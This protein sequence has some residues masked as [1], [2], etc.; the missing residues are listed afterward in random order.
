MAHSQ[1]EGTETFK[2]FMYIFMMCEMEN[3]TFG[4]K[5]QKWK[6]KKSGLLKQVKQEEI[7]NLLTHFLLER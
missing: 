1:P 3:D 2:I 5:Y 6:K 4:N 7:I